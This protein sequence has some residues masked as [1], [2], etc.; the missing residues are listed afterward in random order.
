LF[1]FFEATTK[2]ADR[3]R[4]VKVWGGTKKGGEKWVGHKVVLGVKRRLTTGGIEEKRGQSRKRER[5]KKGWK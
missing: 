5:K 2:K 4:S 1:G 3:K